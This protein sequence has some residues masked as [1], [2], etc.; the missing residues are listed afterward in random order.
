MAI[1]GEVKNVRNLALIDRLYS[2]FQTE[3]GYKE[4]VQM[5][6]TVQPVVEMDKFNKTVKVGKTITTNT[7]DTHSYVVPSGKRWVFSYFN[8]YRAN[9][10][11][12]FINLIIGGVTIDFWSGTSAT[13]WWGPMFNPVIMNT[14]DTIYV[15]FNAGTSGTLTSLVYYIEESV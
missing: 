1:L 7:T 13:E 5:M 10:A 11:T 14:G 2:L 3:G 8:L 6:P 9:A 15:G 4:P 12:A